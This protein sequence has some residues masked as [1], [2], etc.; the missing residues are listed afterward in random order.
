MCVTR[1]CCCQC[2]LD[3]NYR[4]S[5]FEFEFQVALQIARAWWLRL[6]FPMAGQGSGCKS[7]QTASAMYWSL[8][9]RVRRYLHTHP[10][11]IQ[12]A[13]VNRCSK[14]YSA[15]KS[16][17]A[18]TFSNKR[19]SHSLTFRPWHRVRQM[20]QR[21]SPYR[22]PICV[23][24]KLT[25]RSRFWA[26]VGRCHLGVATTLLVKLIELYVWPGLMHGPTFAEAAAVGANF[27]N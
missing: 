8:A 6:G 12:G 16:C 3:S 22:C 23:T 11:S 18:K 1:V 17:G 7:P 9:T 24:T 4:V 14:P 2:G 13:C 26:S 15:R 19:A 10:Q 25:L 27:S 21:W 20:C 5:R